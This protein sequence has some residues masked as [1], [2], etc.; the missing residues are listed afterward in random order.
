MMSAAIRDRSAFHRSRGP[1]TPAFLASLMARSTATQA[2]SFECVKCCEPPRTSQIPSSGVSQLCSTKSI[3]CNWSSHA[4]SS[5]SSP[6]LR[7]W[8]S[9]SITSP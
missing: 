4:A 6:A 1:S 8:C 7:A 9:A 5:G 3:R 2:I